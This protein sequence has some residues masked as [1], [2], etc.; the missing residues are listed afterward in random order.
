MD[1]ICLTIDGIEVRVPRGTTILNAARKAGIYIPALCDHPDL[2]PIG[3]CKLCIV[4][5]AGWET[6]PTSCTTCAENGMVVRTDT[7][8]IREMRRNTLE[9]LLA[10]TSHPVSCLICE[11]KRECSELKECM[12]KFPATVGC[13][14]CPK[15]G[16]CEIQRAAE[17]L[18]LERIR[19]PVSYKGLPVLRE[20][21]F[22]RDYNLCIMCGRCAR[23]C[24]EL[25]GEGVLRMIAD[26]H[27]G[28]RIGPESL[29]ESN[30]KFCGACVDACPT[31]ALH[32][33]I[34][35]WERAERSAVTTC[36]FCGVGCQMEVGARNN[37]IVRV[38]GHRDGANEGQLCVKGRFGLEFAESPDRL[39]TPMI[40][41]N[42]VLVSATWDEALDLIAERLRSFRGDEFG[43]VASAKCTNEEVYLAQKFARVVMGTNNIDNCARLCHASTIS[44]LSAAIGSGAMTNSIDDIRRAGCIFVI[45]SNTTEQHPVIGLRIKEA[46]RR[47]ARIIVVNP[48]RIELCDIADIWL[49]NRP[50]TDLPL[51]LGM[52]KSIKDAG[53]ADM[54]FI[55]ERT[56]GFEDF[57]RSL[58]ELQMDVV[59][60]IT[61]VD[62]S[63]IREAALLY[64]SSK[65]SSIVY[66]M[67]ITQHVCGTDNV[68]ALANLAM[69]TGNIG[70]PGGGINP[71]RGQNNVQGACDMGA[72]PKMLP[73]YQNVMS[74]EARAMIEGIWG[75][76]IPE[77]PGLTLVEMFDAARS[78]RIK[79]MYIMG[80]NP[81]LSEPDAGHVI[82]AL[83]GLDFL[84]VQDIFLTE[85]A[86]LAD[87]VL[88]AACSLEKDGT[89]TSTERRVQ[90]VRR[91][92]DPPGDARPDWWIIQELALR[93][94]YR[95]GF[96]F[97]STA[98]IMREI[99]RVARIY[100][101]ISHERLESRGIQ[102]PCT[103][104][105]HPGTPYLHRDGFANGRGRFRVLRYRPPEELPDS[106]Y[107]MV[108]LTGRI[109]YHYHTGTMTRRV[110]DLEYLRG[111]EVVEMN[112]EDGAKMGLKDGDLVE[113]TSRRG[114]VM[115]RARLTERSPRGT[116]FMTF[117]F[118][119]TPTNVLTS[120]FLDPVAKIPELKFCAVRIKKI[121]GSQHVQNM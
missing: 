11:R 96:S 58:D 32:A 108:L 107:P 53:L 84:V 78:G 5:I 73:G 80:E 15:D 79:A 27:R 87:V 77:R 8:K 69:M 101:G 86:Q 102:W 42:S 66:S 23:I 81:V 22:D 47:G 116:V 100:G 85:T 25:R 115:A 31:G 16:E 67:G 40:R 29:I 2:K 34:E 56:E 88:P 21:F 75:M 43:M 19:Y 90:M 82:E 112:P 20:P 93:M 97:S 95:K 71:L 118:S 105:D 55:R 121:Q 119:E 114:S 99:S 111:E 76:R 9:L 52:C 98:D 51:I 39:R 30:C 13:K 7:S 113:I 35:K 44:G 91:I 45:G 110:H 33:R 4:E 61:G 89:F 26:Y 94:G 3:I 106:E 50:G 83:K 120:R 59:S 28:S 74:A 38:R 103:D 68:L 48:R 46:K 62:E 12:R 17:H 72:L 70:V 36:P 37:H 1:E 6:Y 60:R 14:Y 10:I 64:A 65:P 92:L 24:S 104:P 63:L 41:K 18:G 117:H 109:L 57:S 54:R 49:R